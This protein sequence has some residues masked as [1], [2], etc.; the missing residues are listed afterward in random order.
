MVSTDTATMMG[1]RK[2]PV[3]DRDCPRPAMM[4]ENSPTWVWAAPARRDVSMVC[5]AARPPRVKNS[6][7]PTM[8]TTASSRIGRIYCTIIAGWT[9]KPTEMKNTPP[10]RFLQGVTRCSTR[11]AWTVPASRDPAKKAPSSVD[12]PMCWAKIAIK[13]HSAR[14]KISST[15]SFISTTSFFIM[16]GTR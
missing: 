6:S 12:S 4:K 10:N 11:S 2:A 3:T 13:K 5:P 9:M 8:A 16:V 14:A 1:Y 15:S 7:F